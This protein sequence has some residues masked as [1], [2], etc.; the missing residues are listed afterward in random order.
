MLTWK[1]ATRRCLACLHIQRFD[2][3]Q[4]ADAARRGVDMS[5]ATP[6]GQKLLQQ[7]RQHR[8]KLLNGPSKA[9][10]FASD[11]FP[12][13]Q[14]LFKRACSAA[15]PNTQMRTNLAACAQSARARV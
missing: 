8:V 14:S 12:I 2:E 4:E 11:S 9:L 1:D 10:S 7:A 6:R 15:R 13:S 5:R 3:T